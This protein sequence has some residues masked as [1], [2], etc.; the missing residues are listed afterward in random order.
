MKGGA[1]GTRKSKVGLGGRRETDEVRLGAV[2]ALSSQQRTTRHP[3][4]QDARPL[5]PTRSKP[6]LTITRANVP[7]AFP[8]LPLAIAALVAVVAADQSMFVGSRWA[9]RSS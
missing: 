8:S 6:K 5:G 3:R 1:F 4:S 7:V 2:G 9:R